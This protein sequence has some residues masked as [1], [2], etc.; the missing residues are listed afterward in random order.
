MYDLITNKFR[1]LNL[2]N[3]NRDIATTT[4]N[5]R[6]YLFIG[7]PNVLDGEGLETPK[8]LVYSP[9]SIHRDMISMKYI[10]QFSPVVERR[11]WATGTVYDEYSNNLKLSNRNFYIIT[12]STVGTSGGKV[13]ICLNNK[14]NG[15][16]TIVPTHDG[17]TG[18]TTA[19][20]P[21]GYTW[22]WIYTIPESNKFDEYN[23]DYMPVINGTTPVGS[24]IVKGVV[25]NGGQGYGDGFYNCPVVGDGSIDGQVYVTVENGAVTIVDLVEG[26]SGEGFTFANIDLRNAYVSETQDPVLP[27][28]IDV[29]LS[30]PGGFGYDNISLLSTKLLMIYAELIEGEGGSFPLI[31]SGD[32]P[33]SYG[34][35]GI[36]KNPLDAGSTS[37][38]NVGSA[39][40]LTE[41]IFDTTTLSSAW[42][43]KSGDKISGTTSG[44][45]GVVVYW[46]GT[47]ILGIHQVNEI[48]KGLN[49]NM[50]LVPFLNDETVNILEEY[51]TI[52]NTGVSEPEYEVYSG[53]I[54]YV[55]N[56]DNIDRAAQQ[57]EIIKL[58]IDFN[59]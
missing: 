5:D 34:Q 54:L 44:A 39:K 3:L 25:N 48:G 42:I 23:G 17:S 55:M 58:V 28:D 21:D 38:L 29:V 40:C 51:G 32:E 1:Y 53:E 7:K 27:A 33:F 47:S 37:N 43:P 9:Q 20:L 35:I 31:S 45:T 59:C 14:S 12:S 36:I 26:F 11:L 52:T 30:P 2:T 19:T 13:Y 6:F 56:I 49:A 24:K 15:Q 16:S 41:L 50:K 10:D 46:D 8:E 22:E 57:K 4:I 18:D